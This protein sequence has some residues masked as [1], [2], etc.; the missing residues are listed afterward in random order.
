M[1]ADMKTQMTKEE[2]SKIV[3]EAVRLYN[4]GKED[5]AVEIMKQYPVPPHIASAVDDVFG[6][7]FLVEQG[8]NIS[9]L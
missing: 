2:K 7:E 6:R 1:E 8:F 4:E 5:E 9:E 3:A